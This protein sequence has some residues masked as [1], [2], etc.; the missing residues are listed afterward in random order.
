MMNSNETNEQC[1]LS[2]LD[3]A[4]FI[5]ERARHVS[6][7]SSCLR[8]LADTI[9]CAMMDGECTPDDWIGSDVGPPKGND[10]STIDWIFLASTLNFSFWTDDNQ[11]ESYCRKYKNNIYYGYYALC[12]AINQALDDGMDI[13]NAE[14]YSK[15]THDQI[16][17]IFRSTENS[18]ELPMLNERL[19]I[20]RETGSILLKEYDGHF[21]RCIEQSGG[22]AVDLVELIVK[23]FPA[24]RDEAVYDGQKVS[25]YKR[26]QILVADIWGCF[27]GHGFGH[28][29]D[30]DGLTMFAD[31]RIPQVLS[32]E[33]VLIYSN[34][35]KCRLERKEEI[36]FGDRDECEIRAAS[37]LAVQLIVNQANEKIPLEKDTGDGGQRL[38]APLVD[39][40][41]WRR[42]RQFTDLYK[43]TPFHRARSIFY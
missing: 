7:N 13:I 37:I 11:N 3:S 34:E 10:Q 43:Q 24:Y 38:N 31:Y 39:V 32:H 15:L 14:Y 29:T 27:N 35:L 2:P 9:S 8:K 20:L 30:M 41:L 6:I 18:S 40:Y 23:K 28:F 1:C 16:K 12:V 21:S 33:G 26:A 5:M 17:Y 4:R 22:S 36:P 25:F 42:R 19:N